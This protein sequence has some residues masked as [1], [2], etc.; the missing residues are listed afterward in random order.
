MII[1]YKLDIPLLETYLPSRF[2]QNTVNLNQEIFATVSYIGPNN[3]DSNTLFY[4]PDILNNFEPVGDSE[5][6]SPVSR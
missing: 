5:T 1:S 6:K 3:T 2:I 4:S